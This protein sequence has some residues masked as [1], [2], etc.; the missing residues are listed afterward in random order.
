TRRTAMRKRSWR[1]LALNGISSP[2][3]DIAGDE[4]TKAVKI[5]LSVAALAGSLGLL[6]SG[7]AGHALAYL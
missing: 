1:P 5:L 6:F 4:E 3:G 2:N 7:V